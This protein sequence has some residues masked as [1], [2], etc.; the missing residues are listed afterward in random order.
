MNGKVSGPIKQRK[1]KKKPSLAL[2]GKKING[3]PEKITGLG[4]LEI[5]RRLGSS[6]H[7][8]KLGWD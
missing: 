3:E 2:K 7:T 4:Y 6:G 1:K 5:P 8:T